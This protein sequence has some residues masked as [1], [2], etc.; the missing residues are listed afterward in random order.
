MRK[1]TYRQLYIPWVWIVGIVVFMAVFA[2][3]PV[4]YAG[5]KDV[6]MAHNQKGL[7]H[8]NSAFY[9][10]T[11]KNKV[12]DADREYASAAVEFKKAIAE[13]PSF[14]EPHKNLARLA[15]I[16]GDFAGANEQYAIV[17]N[18][19]ASDLDAFINLALARIQLGD[20]DGA[21]K[22]LEEAKTNTADEKAR[23]RLDQ[24]I[25]KVSQHGQIKPA[26]VAP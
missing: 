6:A 8:F 17:T 18:L 26:E 5:D 2:G 3:P 15:Y 16:Q 14:P 19:D 1:R 24:Y 10:H 21:I 11:P 7:D 25:A 22:A 13:D 4:V 9:D 23:T 20:N 12:V